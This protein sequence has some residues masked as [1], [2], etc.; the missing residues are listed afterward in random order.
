MSTASLPFVASPVLGRD[1]L[2]PCS[3]LAY[4]TRESLALGLLKP[5]EVPAEWRRGWGI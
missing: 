5:A 1:A 3:R 4:F 2:D